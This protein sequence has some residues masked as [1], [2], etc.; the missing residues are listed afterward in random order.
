MHR[1]FRDSGAMAITLAL[2]TCFILVP[3]SGFVVDIGMMRVARSDMQAVAD[4]A[5]LDTARSLAAGTD[6][7]SGLTAVAQDSARRTSGTVGS[8]PTVSAY[9][10]YVAG[11]AGF[12]SDQ[13]LGCG[14]APIHNDYFAAVPSGKEPNAVLVTS[15]AD[16]D[17]AIYGGSGR[18]C[19]ASIAG[20]ANTACFK[21]GSYAAAVNSGDS[22]VLS[23]LNGLLG[24]D[25]T[26]VG[27]QGLAN[28]NVTLSQVAA[29]SAVGTT[30]EL[31]T[32][33]VSMRDLTVATIDALSQDPAGNAAAISALNSLLG[34]TATMGSVS[35]ADVLHVDPDDQAALATS[36]DVLDLL[37]GS[38]LVA[39]GGSGFWV[40]DAVLWSGVAGTGST[41]LQNIRVVQG[42]SI[43]CG[44]PGSGGA[45]A[46]SSQVSGSVTFASMNT[47]S[48]NLDVGNLKTDK[49]TGEFT[50]NVGSA[51]AALADSP[52]IHCGAGTTA[53]PTTFDVDVTTSV[54]SAAL[55]VHIPV[56]GTVR[57]PYLSLAGI[58][59]GQ[60]TVALDLTVDIVQSIS[61]N[62]T[63]TRVTVSIPPNDTTPVPVGSP[64]ALSGITPS[65]SVSSTGFSATVTV[66][67]LGIVNVGTNLSLT[68]S[69]LSAVLGKIVS[70]LADPTDP[71]SFVSQSLRPLAANI[72][73]NFLGPLSK[74]LGLRIGGADLYGIR[75]ACGTPRI[76]G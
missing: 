54:A 44:A 32:G 37:A 66:G 38:A 24:L 19:R 67:L 69:T 43:A 51:H 1:E 20:V 9:P 31:L 60:I 3:L 62:G 73:A 57:V 47:P 35:L 71:S 4:S 28:A 39:D 2:V 53:D 22:A 30:S 26:L 61:I 72:D 76:V 34:I 5:A 29:S 56:S 12:V 13:S 63:T 58:P 46:D 25:L 48:I 75:A 36:F 65:G 33:S 70:S 17:H 74:V 15:S 59:L 16:V 8:T 50:V 23:T 11:D 14:T 27:Y 10:G 68:S 18:V 49:G 40:P 21:M 55:S 52:A 45:E 7:A 41:K 64:L 42:P 6:S